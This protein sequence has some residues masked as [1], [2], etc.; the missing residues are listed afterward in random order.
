MAGQ[1][2]LIENI[3]GTSRKILDENLGMGEEVRV[4]VEGVSGQ[5]VA[6]TDRRL[7]I[8]KTGL[9]AG[10]AFVG[11]KCKSFAYDHVTTIDCNKG[12]LA[13]RFQVSAAGTTEVKGGYMTAFEA[14]NVVNFGAGQYAKFQAA[15][16][17]IRRLIDI[18]KQQ[19]QAVPQA[20]SIPDQ[21]QKLA[22]LRS[23]GILTEQ[24]FQDKKTE[25]LARL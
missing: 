9:S 7:L 16:N 12:L 23:A 2:E 21:I 10:G 24:E 22:E 18:A 14:E 4:F 20:L 5:S 8:I 13:G 6:A 19:S 3:R 25:L 1:I 17:E 15:T 11:K